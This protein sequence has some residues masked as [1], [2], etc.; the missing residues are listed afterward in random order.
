MSSRAFYQSIQHGEP[1]VANA[2]FVKR[3]VRWLGPL[4]RF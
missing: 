2:T 3:V 1:S 4:V